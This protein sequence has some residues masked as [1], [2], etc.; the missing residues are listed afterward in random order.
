MSSHPLTTRVQNKSIIANICCELLFYV[1]FPDSL[2]QQT[3]YDIIFTPGE[4]LTQPDIVPS[5]REPTTFTT[6]VFSTSPEST[7]SQS[8]KKRLAFHIH[9][10]IETRGAVNMEVFNIANSTFLA[11]ANFH[12]PGDGYS[13][14]SFIY[15]MN[16]NTEKFEI[17]Q[18]LP[19]IGCRSMT[20]FSDSGDSFLVVTNHFDGSTH[21]LD[22]VIYKWNGTEF[23]N[24]TKIKTHGASAAQF[25]NI[26]GESFLAFANYRNN[27]S[28]SIFSIVYKWNKGRLQVFQKLPTHGA[29]DCKFHR[30]KGGQ[31]F[32]VY[33]NYYRLNEGFNVKS[34]VYKWDGQ[35]FVFAQN[36]EASAAMSVDLFESDEGLFLALAS[37]RTASTWHSHTNVYRWNGTSFISFQELETTAAIKVIKL[38]Y[39][40]TIL[41]NIRQKKHTLIKGT[42]YFQKFSFGS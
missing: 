24:Y 36:V 38:L 14:D 34:V 26:N 13:T 6:P 32:L 22:S 33:A 35:R 19:T 18:T 39:Q 7:A 9:D 31:I 15:R 40:R 21:T 16:P 4:A 1:I 2:I 12:L 30:S 10:K 3:T 41:R 17:L 42:P 8:C 29:V 37:H 23:V 11:V 28:V 20:Y 25:F 5:T 27:T